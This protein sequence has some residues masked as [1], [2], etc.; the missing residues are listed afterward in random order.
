MGLSIGGLGSGLDTASIVASLMQ[1]ER[2]PQDKVY[3]AQGVAQKR[4]TAW[5]ELRTKTA[6]LQGLAEALRTPDKAVASTATSSDTSLRVSAAVGAPTGQRSITVQR[7]A[8]AATQTFAGLGAAGMTVGAGTTVLSSGPGTTGATVDLSRAEPGIHVISVSRPSTAATAWTAPPRTLKATDLTVQ[9]GDDGTPYTFD[10]EAD[11]ADD[12]A[13]LKD[14]KDKLDGVLDVSLVAGRL[15]LKVPFEGSSST[16]LLSGGAAAELGLPARVAG[17]SA[18]VTVDGQREEVDPPSSGT[19]TVE[20]GDTGI[21][22]GVSAA[23]LEV[24]TIRTNVV[25]TTDSS[26]LLDLQ[27]ALNGSGSP[28]SAS[29][30]PDGSGSRLVLTST[31]TGDD[32][33]DTGAA[34]RPLQLTSSLSALAGGGQW[35]AG[36]DALL[37]VDGVSVTRSSNSVKDLVP[38]VTLDLLHKPKDPVTVAVTRDTSGTK[39]KVSALVDGMNALIASVR[40]QTK[41]EPGGTSNGALAGNSTARQLSATLFSK[42]AAVVPAGELRS[43]SQIGIQTTRAGDFTFSASTLQEALDKD[44]D[45]VAS[46]VAGFADSVAD[47]AQ[48]TSRTGGLLTS[49]RDGAQ[50]EVDARQ[51]EY[52][53]Y[54]DRLARTEARYKAQY[55][56]L[57]TA[58]AGLKS[59]QS[60]MSAALS[61]LSTSS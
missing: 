15:Q 31:T 56:A 52:D 33:D 58:M 37:D 20:L 42:A 14:L 53:A 16:L 22:L 4:V 21:R 46:V 59:Q 27:T 18:V 17:Q 39:D 49:A 43:L 9:V 26:T 3:A 23:G 1:V 40:A 55:A 61:G 24:G 25:R 8:T 13:A 35:L 51:K 41:S 50:A 11:Y 44:P 34:Q 57:E 28:V 7:L 45:A 48:E 2:I 36:Q 29:L 32:T 30:L 10:L 19:D 12:A 38:G 47:W 6:T 54:T 5:S 60:A